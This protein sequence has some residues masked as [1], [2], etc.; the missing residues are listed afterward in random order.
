MQVNPE[1]VSLLEDAGLCFTGKD[2]TGRRM[3][4]DLNITFTCCYDMLLFTF[5]F[6]LIF[7]YAD[8][9]ASTTSLFYWCTISS[10]V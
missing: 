8:R 2:E 6:M 5:I 4:V 10:R 3:E 9:R 1:M 7:G